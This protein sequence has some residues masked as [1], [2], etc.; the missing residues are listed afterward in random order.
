MLLPMVA[1][2]ESRF[3]F[4]QN[5]DFFFKQINK[6]GGGY[7]QVSLQVLESSSMDSFTNLGMHLGILA[8]PNI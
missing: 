6:L 7:G 8:K 5:I 1:L 4:R 3:G 2:G